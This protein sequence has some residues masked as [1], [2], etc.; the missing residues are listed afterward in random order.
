M[1]LRGAVAASKASGAAG[2][3][4]KRGGKAKANSPA[5]SGGRPQ[6][7]K[8]V[9]KAKRAAKKVRELARPAPL[10]TPAPDAILRGSTDSRPFP[11]FLHAEI[12]RGRSDP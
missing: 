10:I 5:G 6:S 4:A 12:N 1:T 2:N 9:A 11:L 7:S 3:R 8:P